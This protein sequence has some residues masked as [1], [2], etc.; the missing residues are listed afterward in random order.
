MSMSTTMVNE[1]PISSVLEQEKQTVKE[2]YN[3]IAEEYDLRF[4]AET[5]SDKRFNEMEMNFILGKLKPEDEVLD[6]GCGTGRFTVPMA[7]R[8]RQVTGLDLCPAMMEKAREKTLQRG[9]RVEFKEGDMTNLQFADKSFDVVTSMVALMHIPL[10]QR[11]AVFSEAARVLKPGGRMIIN[12]KNATFEGICPVDRFVS[13]DVTDIENKQLVFTQN[14]TG[15]DLTTNW[16][17]FSPEDINRLFST[18]G[19]TLV[20]MRANIPIF[21][22]L[23]NEV[24]QPANIFAILGSLENLLADLPP[25][26]QLGYYTLAEAVKP[27]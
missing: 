16:Y 7:E 8:V 12:V 26:N 4:S 14:R 3:V 6:L 2:V 10:D 19:L 20:H 18:A 22:W 11:Q 27:L 13:V 1:Q 25:F 17:S 23:A 21:A 15:N 24:V 5:P 9:L